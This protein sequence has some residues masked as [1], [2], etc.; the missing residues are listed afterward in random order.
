MNKSME[1]NVI[2]D[3]EKHTNQEIF[4]GKKG[5]EIFEIRKNYFYCLPRALFLRGDDVFAEE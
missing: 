5:K 3:E 1:E 4:S 2:P